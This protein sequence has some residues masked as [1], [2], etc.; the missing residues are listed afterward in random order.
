[1]AVNTHLGKKTAYKLLYR[2][3][4]FA[5]CWDELACCYY[6]CGQA[7]VNKLRGQIDIDDA[8]SIKFYMFSDQTEGIFLGTQLVNQVLSKKRKMLCKKKK[9]LESY[10]QTFATRPNYINFLIQKISIY[11]RNQVV[12][13]VGMP[14]IQLSIILMTRR[15]WI[16]SSVPMATTWM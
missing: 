14:S 4:W 8:L 5:N 12:S 10:F 13:F 6:F 1:M 15:W 11:P 9:T 7:W 16:L 3:I 2:T